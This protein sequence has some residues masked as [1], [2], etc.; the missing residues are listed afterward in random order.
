MGLGRKVDDPPRTMLAPDRFDRPPIGNV[1]LDKH[2]PRLARTSSSVLRF[3]RIGE[4]VN[5]DYAAVRLRQRQPNEVGADEPSSAGYD[6]AV[7]HSLARR[8][9]DQSAWRLAQIASCTQPLV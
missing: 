9:C 6:D 2:E 7:H 8:A 5:H 1:G 4:R 3:A